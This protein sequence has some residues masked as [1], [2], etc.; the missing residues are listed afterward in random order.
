[1]HRR[2]R[3]QRA[4]LARLGADV[5]L[6]FAADPAGGADLD[7][8]AD[9][10]ASVARLIRA[11]FATCGVPRGMPGLLT[12]WPTVAVL[13]ARAPRSTCGPVLAR[14]HRQVTRT[15]GLV[16]A[17]VRAGLGEAAA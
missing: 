2:A 15:A 13:V 8:L 12:P 9:A 10:L 16:A 3:E 14:S 4:Q 7:V 17:V 1:V 11:S 5:T 6:P